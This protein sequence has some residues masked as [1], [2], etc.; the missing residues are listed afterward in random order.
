MVAAA[1]ALALGNYKE[2]CFRL[3]V[4][5]IELHSNGSIVAVVFLNVD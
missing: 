5:R 2:F 4:T 3:P 1:V